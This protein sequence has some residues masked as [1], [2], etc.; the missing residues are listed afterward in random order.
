MP[1]ARLNPSGA[2]TWAFCSGAPNAEEGLPD[3]PTES[4]EEGTVTHWLGDTCLVTGRP[5][6]NFLGTVLFVTA[7][8]CIEIAMGG[9]PY[10]FEPYK[11]PAGPPGHLWSITE[12]MCEHVQVYLDHCYQLTYYLQ[13]KYPGE[14][15]ETISERRVNPGTLMGRDD[16]WGTTDYQAIVAP[17]EIHIR[18]FKYVISEVVTP[19]GNPQLILYA[20][21]AWADLSDEQRD[22]IEDIYLGIVQP[23][24]P[25]AMGQVVRVV[26]M[27]PQELMIWLDWFTVRASL[28][29]NPDALRTPSK[30]SCKWCKALPTCYAVTDTVMDVVADVTDLD[31]PPAKIVDEAEN[32]LLADPAGIGRDRLFAILELAPLARDFLKAVV[33]HCTDLAMDGVPITNHKVVQSDTNRKWKDSPDKVIKRI[34]TNFKIPKKEVIQ[35]EKPK[36]P[37]QMEAVLRKHELT[38]RQKKNFQ[39][40]IIKPPGKPTLVP[41]S[42]PRPAMAKTIED[43]TQGMAGAIPGEQQ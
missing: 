36:S 7:D 27:S 35:D 16:C 30:E 14:P 26:R 18:D 23:R 33:S 4:G 12:T 3:R 5:P 41:E 40:M 17:G 32:L 28:T 21:G 22:Q 8:D 20:L 6:L 29:D 2:K 13:E 39:D 31:Q 9:G 43:Q 10:A 15:V 25:D 42:D 34:A 19:Q 11:D 38:D 24:R 1:H 37:R